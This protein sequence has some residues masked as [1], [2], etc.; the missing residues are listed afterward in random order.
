MSD[1]KIQ[2]S[3]SPRRIPWNKGKPIGAKN[4]HCGRSTF[5]RSAPDWG[6]RLDGQSDRQHSDG[7]MFGEIAYGRLGNEGE[8]ASRKLRRV[9]GLY[10]FTASMYA[11]AFV[12]SGDRH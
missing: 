7:Q 11:F 8:K 3:P 6:P 2:Y 5:G 10:L 1:I 12:S 4:L 9:R